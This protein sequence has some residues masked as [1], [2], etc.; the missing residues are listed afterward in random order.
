MKRILIGVGGILLVLLL[1]GYLNRAAIT[2][3]LIG[4]PEI[5]WHVDDPAN[6]TG[7]TGRHWELEIER[8]LETDLIHELQWEFLDY[9]PHNPERLIAA[10]N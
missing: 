6:E 10:G 3:Q 9:S 5:L 4:R 2:L 1:V 7:G 8:W